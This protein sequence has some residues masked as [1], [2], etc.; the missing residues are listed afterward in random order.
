MKIKVLHIVP[1]FYPG[2]GIDRFVLNCIKKAPSG[3]FSFDV[4]SHE[5]GDSTYEKELVRLGGHVEYFLPLGPGS[6]QRNMEKFREL[7]QECHYDVVHCHM[8]NAAFIYLHEARRVGIPI[9]VLHSHQDRYADVLSHVLRNVP[10]VALGRRHANVRLACSESAGKFLFRNNSFVF[11]PNGIETAQFRFDEATRLRIRRDLGA[12][13]DETLLLF[14]GRLVPQ[15]NPFFALET[16]KILL[17]QYGER[18]R[19][20]VAGDGFLRDELLRAA[21]E[22][23]IR[24]RV[25]FLGSVSNSSDYLCAADALLMPS[26]YEGLGYSLVEAQANGLRCFISEAVPEEG[27]ITD[28]VQKLPISRSSNIWAKAIAEACP[29][30]TPDTPSLI[31]KRQSYSSIVAEAGFDISRTTE[32]LCEIYRSKA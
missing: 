10:L 28:L 19:L 22:A 26:R 13:P 32:L 3:E 30:G 15:K 6:I 20:V 2:G 16:I 11:V 12:P 5:K 4:I 14:L 27:C 29:G 24:K 25:Y 23:G 31:Q 1:R 9:R 18:Y 17:S 21:E 8:A 7:C